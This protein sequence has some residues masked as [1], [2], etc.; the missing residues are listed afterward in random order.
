MLADSDSTVGSAVR[1]GCQAAWMAPVGKALAVK[2]HGLSS[3]SRK[4]PKGGKK[5]L[6]KRFFSSHCVTSHSIHT[7]HMGARART[8]TLTP[9]PT[10]TPPPTQ[11]NQ[12]FKKDPADGNKHDDVSPRITR[13]PW[14]PTYHLD[15]HFCPSKI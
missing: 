6:T 14:Y 5:E 2:A 1:G 9:T 13:G 11:I 7:S 10:H 4:Q 12:H 3:V 8:H 15:L